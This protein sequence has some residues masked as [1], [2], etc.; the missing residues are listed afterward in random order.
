MKTF[1]LIVLAL[2]VS[3]ATASG[4]GLQ[5]RSSR[6]AQL[7]DIDRY[8]K[9]IQRFIEK[10]PKTLRTFAKVA[11]F[12]T[13]ESHWREFARALDIEAEEVIMDEKSSV[14]QKNGTL[15]AAWFT[16]TSQSENWVRYVNYYFREDGTLARMHVQ[17]DSFYGNLTMIRD[18]SYSG[19]GSCVLPPDILTC[20][21]RRRW[22]QANFRTSRRR[23][24]Q[25]RA[26]SLSTSFCEFKQSKWINRT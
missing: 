8:V 15:V 21:Q 17:L 9:Q 26:T 1:L 18:R 23:S 14:F 12:G 25:T 5:S 3:S 24:T 6:R 20:N 2:L 16:V 11:P 4:Q 7:H 22:S 13:E 19:S 10:N